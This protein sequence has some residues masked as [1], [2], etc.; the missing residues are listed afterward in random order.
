MKVHLEVECTPEEMRRAFGLPDLAPLHERYTASVADAMG[1]QIKPEAIEQLVKSWGP[2]GN[3][4]L[5]LWRRVV[6]SGATPPK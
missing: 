3:A 6:E 1:G 4:G 5:E 2:L